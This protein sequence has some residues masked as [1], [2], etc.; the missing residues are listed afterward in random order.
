MFA[1]FVGEGFRIA[2]RAQSDFIKLTVGGLTIL[3]GLQVFFI[4][5]DVFR[6][7]PLTGI[8]LPFMAYGGS[9]LICNYLLVAVLLRISHANATERVGGGVIQVDL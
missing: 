1:V 9:A 2:Q 3:M 8:T 7:V 5:A 6:L 4:M